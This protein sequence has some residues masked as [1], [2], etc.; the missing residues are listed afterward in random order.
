[1]AAENFLATV[2][3]GVY[4]FFAVSTILK[5]EDSSARGKDTF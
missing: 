2:A 4:S 3:F 1:L 5:E